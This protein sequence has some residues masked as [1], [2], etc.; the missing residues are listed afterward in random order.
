MKLTHTLKVL[1]A[2]VGAA[3]MLITAPVQAGISEHQVEQALDNA[4]DS[5]ADEIKV[6]VDGSTVYLRGGPHA[7]DI[8][9]DAS[10]TVARLQG[11]DEI[12]NE[13]FFGSAS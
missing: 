6:K 10:L 5:K 1:P 11:V 8:V 4:L 13:L 9:N 2:A 7:E 12:V 3:L